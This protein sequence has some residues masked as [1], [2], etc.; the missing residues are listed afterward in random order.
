MTVITCAANGL[1]APLHDRM[2]VIVEPGDD[3]R[4][5][6]PGQEDPRKVTDILLPRQWPGMRAYQ[7]S[8]TV[9]S[10]KHEGAELVDPIGSG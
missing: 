4:W 7:V 2:P 6:D 10:P 8:I 3:D 5:L 1:V 9:N